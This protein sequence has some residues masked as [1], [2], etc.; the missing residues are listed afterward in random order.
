MSTITQPNP[1]IVPSPGDL[2]H[3]TVDQYD[4][5]VRDRTI[6]EDDPVELL[7]GIVVWKMPRGPRHVTATKAC[8]RTLRNLVD[9]GW[10]VAKEDPVRIPDYDEPEPDIAV[11]RGDD[12][13]Y[14]NHHPGPADISLIIEVADATLT[15]DQTVKLQTYAVARI[16]IYWIVNL[17]D[18]QVEVY[19][20]PD[21][22]A[23]V[24]KVRVDYV[25]GQDVPVI[26]D[27]QEVGRIPVADILP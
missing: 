7:N 1:M 2:Y 27:G 10:H 15:R 8:Q 16:P 13:A 14:A 5:M 20:D 23:G 3:F 24:Y 26:I 9:A 6:G 12:T 4:Q 11:I 18:G 19:S 17:I 21:Q 22:G 25:R